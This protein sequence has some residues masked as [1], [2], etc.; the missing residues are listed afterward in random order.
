MTMEFEL[1]KEQLKGEYRK[2]F[3]AA[4]IYGIMKNVSNEMLID[5]LTEIYDILLTAQTEG[6]DVRRIAGTDTERFCKDLYG[7]YTLTDR[8]KF[9]PRIMYTYAWWIFV[10]ALVTFTADNSG[11]SNILP[12]LFG[13]GTGVIFEL[14][15]RFVIAKVMFKSRKISP[16]AWNNMALLIFVAIFIG[17]LFSQHYI[18]VQLNVPTLPLIIGSGVYI[19]VFFTARSIYRYKNFGTIRNVHKQMLKDNYYKELSSTQ[20]EETVLKGWRKRYEIESSKGKITAEGFVER[21]KKDERINDIVDRGLDIFYAVVYIFTIIER[22]TDPEQGTIDLLFYALIMGVF[23]FLIWRF[24]S[25]A[26]R[27][28]SGVRKKLIQECL[29]A[30]VTMPEYI[31]NRLQ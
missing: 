22:M 4:W 7:D 26:F 20:L 24:F 28:G 3:E 12:Y 11:R 29:Q 2:I 13:I 23:L 10:I 30:G 5:R 19:A 25:G 15:C 27:K 17:M 18:S 21:L 1:M 16:A 9:I 14:I 31:N 6:R 8:I